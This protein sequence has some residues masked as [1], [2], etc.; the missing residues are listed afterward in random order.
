MD[1]SQS[2]TTPC[3]GPA[4]D[5]NRRRTRRR[6][7][8]IT[9]F[10]RRVR[11]PCDR[12]T[13]S[14]T[15]RR[16]AIPPVWSQLQTGTTSNS[17]RRSRTACQYPLR[18]RCISSSSRCTR[19]SF[20]GTLLSTLDPI[21]MVR[22]APLHRNEGHQDTPARTLLRHPR[23]NLA[24]ISPTSRRISWIPTMRHLRRPKLR[25][26]PGPFRR[27]RRPRLKSPTPSRPVAQCRLTESA[28]IANEYRAV[29][30]LLRMAV[31]CCH[32]QR[33][34]TNLGPPSTPRLLSRD[35]PS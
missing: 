14:V 10:T 32:R 30:T 31:R 19:K 8:S 15:R 1:I 9:T 25:Q 34:F 12:R 26:G 18:S 24:I 16:T 11:L 28:S 5:T 7:R 4:Q 20:T 23:T 29:V 2:R 33:A 17:L 22:T 6:R 21:R 35:L 3:T 13:Y 27:S